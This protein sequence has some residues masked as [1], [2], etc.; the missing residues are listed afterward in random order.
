MTRALWVVVW[1]AGCAQPSLVRE[2]L[3]QTQSVIAAAHAVYG[4]LCAPEELARAQAHLDFTRIELHQGY[5][6][7]A[8]EHV[9][10][11]NAA[12]LAALDKATPCG[13]VDQDK[14]GVP[15]IVDRCV[16]EPEDKDGDRDEDGCRDI[17]PYGDDDGDGVLN[18]EDG[19][20]DEP[21]DKD[22]HNDEDGCPETS[23]DSD[24]DGIVEVVDQCPAEPED[25]DGFQDTDGCPDPDNDADTV[26]DFRDACASIPED[27]DD[28]DDEDGCPDPDNDADGVPDKFDSCPNTAGDRDK[29]GCPLEDADKDGI[30]DANDRCPAEPETV[31]A[32]L[33]EDGCPDT[34]PGSVKVTNTRVEITETVQFETGSATLLP[35][36]LKLLDDVVTVLRDAPSMKLR[37]EGHTDSEGP[38][39][40]NMRLS[41][42]RAQSVRV[43][44]ESQGVDA[45]RLTSV[46]LGET[47][48]LD[49]N[50]TPSG[51]AK[52]RRVEFH[53]E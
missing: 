38:D 10:L 25:R 24:G 49:T 45:A 14:D 3:D 46:G 8:A 34:P 18:H 6:G 23:E 47:R 40:T 32:Y 20:V 26:P 36:S 42:E 43:Y 35:A 29:A 12:A 44:L 33:D 37:V 28:W 9:A 22:G 39:D 16:S 53:I 41:K 15:D 5:V 30:A 51:R 27:L 50:R 11:S 19:C 7:R 21:E 2:Q 17:D 1:V 31:N 48:P 52:N 13:G 4:P